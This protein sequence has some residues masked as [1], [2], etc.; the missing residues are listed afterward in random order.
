MV[1]TVDRV[2]EEL[3]AIE[4]EAQNARARLERTSPMP[5][6]KAK[7]ASRVHEQY[8]KDRI[9]AAKKAEQEQI[10]Q[11]RVTYEKPKKVTAEKAQTIARKRGR[12]KGT[13]KSYNLKKKV[14]AFVEKDREL[15]PPGE[16]RWASFGALPEYKPPDFKLTRSGYK[17]LEYKAIDNAPMFKS[18]GFKTMKYEPIG[19]EPYFKSKE[20]VPI[21]QFGAN[22]QYSEPVKRKRRKT[23]EPRLVGE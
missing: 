5:A 20:Y 11:A 18:T 2:R 9:R 1:A 4:N 21:G 7:S 13:T 15:A 23:K 19:N 16:K 12:P 3:E 14:R 17:P 10:E 22:R 8:K 6:D